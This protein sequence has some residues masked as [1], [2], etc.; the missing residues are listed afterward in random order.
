MPSLLVIDDD[1]SIR[2]TIK[3]LLKDHANII[4]G[5][6]S[7]EALDLIKTHNPDLILLDDMLPGKMSGLQILEEIKSKDIKSPPIIMLTASNQTNK[8]MRALMAGAVD[9]I[10][11]PFDP[12]ELVKKIR[13]Y[14]NRMS[15]K[16]LIADDDEAVTEL[17]KYKFINAGFNVVCVNEGKSAWTQ[18]QK[19]N[20][21]LIIL[22]YMMPGFDGMSILKMMKE[23]N[24]LTKTPVIF[25]TA[26]HS[27]AHINMG[28]K[29]GAIDYI[30]K[31]FDSDEVITRCIK[32]LNRTKETE[33]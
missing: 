18:I 1:A 32:V 15:Q 3:E 31:P 25:L 22:D 4:T 30:K 14:F 5:E 33:S 7:E 23:D 24:N 11:K 29:N 28:L 26:K 21:A 17:L 27:S 16:I 12:E 8:V 10:T 2:N 13:N 19:Q 6:N 20:F 9:Y